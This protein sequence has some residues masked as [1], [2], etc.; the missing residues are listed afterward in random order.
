MEQ[1]S[2][3]AYFASCGPFPTWGRELIRRNSAY[4][5]EI[6]TH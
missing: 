4:N 3:L 5:V 1:I 6:P 2:D